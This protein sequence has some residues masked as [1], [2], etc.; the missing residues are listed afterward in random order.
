MQTTQY[1]E[2]RY[3]PGCTTHC[4]YVPVPEKHPWYA[5]P[6]E[7]LGLPEIFEGYGFACMAVGSPSP[8]LPRGWWI[9]IQCKDPEL[10]RDLVRCVEITLQV[11]G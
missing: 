5:V 7:R 10:L 2:I 11:K 8:A 6:F 3:S 9:G 4:G 1:R